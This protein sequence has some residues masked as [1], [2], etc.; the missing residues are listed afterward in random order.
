M[1]LFKKDKVLANDHSFKALLILKK[2]KLLKDK[3]LQT[4]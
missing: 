3:R 4:N 2:R 1:E